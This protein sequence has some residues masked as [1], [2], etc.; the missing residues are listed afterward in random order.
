M[1]RAA[2]RRPKPPGS[3]AS[4]VPVQTYPLQVR[5]AQGL[6]QVHTIAMASILQDSP[7]V[8]RG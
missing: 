6:T 3:E 8:K 5:V 4:F 2:V 7:R 1:R